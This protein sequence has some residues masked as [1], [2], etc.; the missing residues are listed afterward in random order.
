M[1][2]TVTVKLKD[3]VSETV[4]NPTMA[5][6][7]ECW[8]V[9]KKDENK[10]DIAEMRLL[11]WIRG[12][13]YDQKGPWHKPSHTRG[14]QSMQNVNIT[15]TENIKLA[16]THQGK[17]RRQP[18]VKSD[19]RGCTGGEKKWRPRRRWLDNTRDGREDMKNSND[20]WHNWKQTVLENNGEV[21]PIK[22]WRWCLLKVREVRTVYFKHVSTREKGAMCKPQSLPNN[23]ACSCTEVDV[24]WL[25]LWELLKINSGKK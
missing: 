3:K 20:N 25:Y 11:G 5:C 23:R 15:E 14:C 12:R 24:C 21:W 2:Q 8:T 18:L 13:P 6:G 16:W 19:G 10:Y 4:I 9:R 17:R 7:E 1:R 22:M